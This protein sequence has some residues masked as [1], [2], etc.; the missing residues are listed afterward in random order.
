MSEHPRLDML[1]DVEIVNDGCIG[2]GPEVFANG[3]HVITESSF[4]WNGTEARYR[5]RSKNG[6]ENENVPLRWRH[7]IGYVAFKHI[8]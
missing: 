3:S 1:A 2:F 4:T 8:Q 5:P 6:V 7:R